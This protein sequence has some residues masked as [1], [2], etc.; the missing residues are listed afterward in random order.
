MLSINGFAQG[1]SAGK[2]VV[3][4]KISDIEGL[5]LDLIDVGVINLLHP[6]GTT[7]DK[8]G[9]YR[10]EVP[11]ET[12]LIIR[13]SH[14]AFENAT[15]NLRLKAGEERKIN[16]SLK[17]KNI[18]I[19]GATVTGVKKRNTFTNL[20]PMSAK[21]MPS[22]SGGVEALIKSLPGVNSNNELSSQ[23][24][25]RGGNFD[26]NLVYV[27]DIEVYRP[28]LTRSGEQ[29]GLSF[30]NPDLISS[31][32]FSSGGFEAKYGDKLSSVLDVQYKTPTKFAGS[33]G[34]SFLGA[35]MHVEG[36]TKSQNFT[37]L[38]GFR[39]K[40]N[41][42]IL[43]SL[44]TKGDYKP[45]FTD[46]QGLFT[47]KID[48]RNEISFLGNISLNSY[49][50]IPQTRETRFGTV[51]LPMMFKVYFE[52]QEIDKFQSYF[53]ALSWLNQTSERL[54]NRFTFSAF[55]S[56]ENEGFDILG[57]YWLSDVD[58]DPASENFGEASYTKG[59]GAYIE[60]A[61]NRLDAIVSS[62]EYRGT[63]V[64]DEVLWQWGM[65]YQY[66]DIV[67]KL[68][69]WR[70]VDS[71]GYSLPTE[72]Q[73][74]GNPNPDRYPPLLQEVYKANHHTKSNRLN[75]FAQA[76]FDFGSDQMYVLSAGLRFSYWDF[77]KEFIA[78]PRINFSYKPDIKPDLLFRFAFG[79]YAQPPFYREI[80]DI[81]GLIHSDV[82]SQKSIHSVVAMDWTF[83]LWNRPFKFTSELYYKYLYDLIPYEIDNI[84][85]R[86][87]AQN[88]SKGYAAGADFRLNGEFVPGV[89]SWLG[90]SFLRTE[91]NITYQDVD[92]EWKETGMIPRPTDQ[93]FSI[94]LYFQDYVTYRKNIKV[95]L[96]MMYA[97]GLPY[98]PNESL[99][100]P[101]L[102][103]QRASSR[104]PDYKR[105]D[106]GGSYLLL[107]SKNKFTKKNPLYY[108]KSIWVS[109]EILNL[110]QMKNTIS[111]DWITVINGG[112]YAVPNQLTP[113]QI[114]V[115]LTVDF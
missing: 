1:V 31:I 69:E 109:L 42:F 27:N 14:P 70:L 37:Y 101:E 87:Y 43:S 4:G 36:A 57:E 18:E 48:K 63:Y 29:E 8:D 88:A 39:Q 17:E 20:D 64:A 56:L 95:Y 92:G 112:Q 38:F 59:V 52:G 98:G 46:M 54:K 86:Y 6:I 111:Y 24:S 67:D 28:L 35:S 2:S 108:L 66:E 94:N 45:S 25:V 79:H 44:Q 53:G 100:N 77:N 12:D 50:F 97:T 41:Q 34:V 84:R 55:R 21:Q 90:F 5:T 11:A 15:I 106:I 83:K 99:K 71:A 7:T 81:Y 65:K 89:E 93:L 82:Q 114:N 85:L 51:H 23:Y 19:R 10:L 105:V 49:K 3:Y 60:H 76:S 30:A 47:Y 22:V 16:R 9:Y 107:G 103:V 73:Q 78:S 80:R 91:E 13:F 110:F 74:P 62:L 33:V 68:N 75:G 58:T 32:A 61:R 104:L 26:E 72:P 113:R 40:S 102:F 96:N 115:K